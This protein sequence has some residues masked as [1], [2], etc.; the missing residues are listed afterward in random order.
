[1]QNGS[2][3]EPMKEM[4]ESDII[5]KLISRGYTILPYLAIVTGPGRRVTSE[6]ADLIQELQERFAY[7][8]E[9]TDKEI[10]G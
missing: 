2:V 4:T 5:E 9:V 8:S 7:T 3:F 10:F 6:E 1:M